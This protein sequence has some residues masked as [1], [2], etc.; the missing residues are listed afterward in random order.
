MKEL[1]NE[2][3]KELGNLKYYLVN[4]FYK[5]IFFIIQGD[6]YYIL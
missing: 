2:R 4:N 6:G 3:F 1:R 5:V